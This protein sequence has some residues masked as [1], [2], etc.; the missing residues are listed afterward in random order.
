MDSLAGS[1]GNVAS[2]MVE[3]QMRLLNALRK[4]PQGTPRPEPET[5]YRFLTVTRDE[6]SLGDAIVRELAQKLN[7][8]ILDKEIV[9]FIAE[10]SHVREDLVRQLDWKSQSLVED[11]ILRFLRMP[12]NKSFGGEEYHASLLRTMAYL[13]AQGNAI[14]L[15]RGSNVALREEAHGLHVRITASPSIR[16]E[17]LCEE[18]QTTPEDARRRMEERD[19]QRRSFVHHHFHQELD[20]PRYYDLIFNTD[21]LT[22]GQVLESILKTLDLSAGSVPPR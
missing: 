21:R 17:R 16:I 6:G 4:E 2:H 5:G 7:W 15:G 3:R 13:A 11:T 10:N 22:M 19:R 12:E 20:N 14:I 9:N 8:K 18:W 1:S